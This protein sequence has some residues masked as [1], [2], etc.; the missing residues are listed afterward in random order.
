VIGVDQ[1]NSNEGSGAILSS[2]PQPTPSIRSKPQIFF[3]K[4]SESTTR[5]YWDSWS[6]IGSYSQGTVVVHCR[7]AQV[8]RREGRDDETSWVVTDVWTLEGTCWRLVARHPELV[9]NT[10]Q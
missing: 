8:I 4:P 6:A 10:P 1:V 2:C 3:K 9:S 7:L 5:H